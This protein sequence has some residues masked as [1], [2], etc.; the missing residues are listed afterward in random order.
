M[1]VNTIYGNESISSMKNVNDDNEI[2]FTLNEQMKLDL[3]S[4]EV[5]LRSMLKPVTSNVNDSLGQN[6]IVSENFSFDPIKRIYLQDFYRSLLS[7]N[8]LYNQIKATPFDM[9][10]PKGQK[11]ITNLVK[12]KGNSSS[13]PLTEAINKKMDQLGSV[14]IAK[15]WFHS[16]IEFAPGTTNGNAVRT[17]GLYDDPKLIAFNEMKDEKGMNYKHNLFQV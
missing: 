2:P 14:E 12:I 9:S 17:R 10:L 11:V 8:F 15:S 3:N 4:I 13:A 16:N 1:S 7:T 6:F 5:F